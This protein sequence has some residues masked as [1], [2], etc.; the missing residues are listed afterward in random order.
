[1]DEVEAQTSLDFFPLLDDEL[2]NRIEAVKWTE[3][4]KKY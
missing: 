3:L 2:E 1:V 4:P